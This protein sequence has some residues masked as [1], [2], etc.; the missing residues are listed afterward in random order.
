MFALL[1]QTAFDWHLQEIY[2]SV[3][4]IIEL[5]LSA[6]VGLV[7]LKVKK[8]SDVQDT[9]SVR[10]AETQE[11]ARRIANGGSV[12]HDLDPK[13]AN[14]LPTMEDSKTDDQSTQNGDIS[15]NAGASRA[16]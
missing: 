16:P 10:I 15:G 8:I 1:L 11:N 3:R 7:L 12:L 9:N 5:V 14:D 13:P 6:G 2:D 4:P